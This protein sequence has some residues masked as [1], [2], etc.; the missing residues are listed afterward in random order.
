MHVA[1]ATG[2]QLP[3]A[4]FDPEHEAAVVPRRGPVG[5]LQMHL[6]ADPRRI[7][8]RRDGAG[9]VDDARHPVVRGHELDD[10]LGQEER[11]DVERHGKNRDRV[12]LRDV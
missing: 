4:A 1:G 8:A 5:E 10:L 7:A 12:D 6:G 3:L 9:S 2:R 11:Q